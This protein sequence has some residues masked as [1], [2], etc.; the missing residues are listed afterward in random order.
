MAQVETRL[1]IDQPKKIELSHLAALG[2]LSLGL[3]FWGLGR[4]PLI[5]PD[6]PRYA[7]IARAMF[8]TGDWVTPRLGG[9]DWFEK[10][11][12]TYWLSAA[13]YSLLG[14]SEFAARFGIALLGTLGALLLYLAGC[15]LRSNRF[16][17][18]SA[19]VLVSSGIWLGFSR[20]ATFDLPLAATMEMALLAFILWEGRKPGR[21]KNLLWILFSFALGLAMLAKGLVGILL[22]SAVIGLYALIA[23]RWRELLRP[24][25]LLSSIAIFLATIS[26]WYGPMLAR[27]GWTFIDEFFIAH[28]FQRYLTN[29]YRHP[30]PFYFFFF[31][32][33]AGCFPW[34]FPLLA[35]IGGLWRR[36][37][38]LLRVEAHRFELF[39]WLWALVPVLFFSFS[40]SKL[41]GYILP[42]FPA[43]AMLIAMQL[44]DWWD[45]AKPSR[46]QIVSVLLTMGTMFLVAVV[47]G[48]RGAQLLG[49][50]KFAAFRLAGMGVLVAVI[51]L[52]IWF[53][54]HLRAA[55]R[56][57]PFGFA[58]VMVA[59]VNLVSP[60]LA[61]R[62]TL[63][64]L[65]E[66]ATH[67]AQPG[68]RLVFFINFNHRINFYATELPLRNSKS[69]F[70][71]A[72]DPAEIP[73][74][75]DR[76]G[77][78]SMLV[79]AQREWSDG[80]IQSPLLR[81]ETLG[82]QRGAVKCSPKCDMILMRAFKTTREK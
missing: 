54:L 50:D 35:R 75:I 16:G 7:E 1:T 24:A 78:Q 57:L 67:Q 79:L 6:E 51:Y 73:L 48:I 63:K 45:E 31:V 28:H 42:V 30:Q 64:A 26:L 15:R 58:V 59:I 81:I 11:A 37:R 10:P 43:L 52:V 76:Y 17:Y 72:M 70:V 13:G 5:G 39:V 66:L 33:A 49:I 47:I 60:A 65:G 21:A 44:E 40:G 23:G 53:L 61:E 29:Q 36:R 77:G 62:E 19:S 27:H 82:E 41:P 9:I 74:L 55:T 69:D 80:L 56:F 8:A 18:L 12:L 20:V 34:S 14:V 3:I 22:P 38:E 46:A 4:L 32:A 2:L 25:W 71:T 68:E